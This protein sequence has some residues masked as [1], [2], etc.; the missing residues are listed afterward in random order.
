MKL[1]DPKND[2]VFKRLFADAP[3][4][5]AELINAIRYDRPPIQELTVLNPLIRPDE[6]RGKYIVL[7]I[8]AADISGERYNVEIQ[9]KC[10]N[11]WGARSAFYLARMLSQ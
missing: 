9:V 10:F 1:L 8:L 5:L 11:D 6:I 3:E 7:D 2:F 4:L